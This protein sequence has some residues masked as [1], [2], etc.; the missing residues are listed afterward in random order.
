MRISFASGCEQRTVDDGTVLRYY[1]I[2][3]GSTTVV[4]LHGMFGS[5]SNWLPIMHDLEDDYR[6][7]SLQLP[8]DAASQHQR[9]RF[10]S[11][12]QL[13]DHVAYLFDELDLD[14]AVVGGNSLGGQVALDFALRAP[15]RV[16]A[17]V[18]T[19]SAGLFE[20]NLAGGSRPK[21]CR[22]FIRDQASQIFYDPNIVCDELVDDIYTM[23]SDRPY[24]KMMLR[25]AKSTR[26][27]NMLEELANVQVPT[28]LVWGRDDTITPPFVAEQFREHIRNSRRVYIDQ[29]GHAPPIEQPAEF[30]T[31]LR[32]FLGELTA[33]GSVGP[34]KPR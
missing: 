16:E 22:N 11:L 25:V 1:D 21:L 3:S 30:A 2:G 28:L 18:L 19:G 32:D 6:F 17:L 10:R 14:R 20:R 8:I 23:L 5:P 34:G 33:A 26:D 27:R 15:D 12:S 7:I 13:T 29:C 31:A 9:S 24:R 4:L